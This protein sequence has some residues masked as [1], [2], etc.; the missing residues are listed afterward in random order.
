MIMQQRMKQIRLPDEVS[1]KVESLKQTLFGA[2]TE[3]DETLEVIRSNNPAICPTYAV[4]DAI[5]RPDITVLFDGFELDW[6][7]LWKGESAE[8]Y[9]LQAPYIAELKED[10]E[11]TDWL[12]TQGFGQGWGIFLRS[13]F[14]ID[15]L[16][17]HLRKF[18]QV[19]SEVDK[20]WLMFRYYS[21]TAI[22]Q[23][24]PYLPGQDF[25]EFM[26]PVNQLMSEIT[27]KSLLVVR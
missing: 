23:I 21:P 7:C 2:L 11:F 17:H 16:T 9:A 20:T 22:N 15:E 24:L 14:A 18:N 5:H 6:R 19:Y 25:V 1:A 12:L 13:Y 3:F 4:I 10:N 27:E 8:K 26:R